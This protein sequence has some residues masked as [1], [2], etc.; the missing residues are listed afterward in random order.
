MK[1]RTFVLLT[2]A[3]VIIMILAII[4]IIIINTKED[5]I[6]E[7]H[8]EQHIDF[9]ELDN[10][11]D[12]NEYYTVK[13]IIS[14]YYTNVGYLD[15]N[16]EDLNLADE[17]IDEASIV[18]EYNQYATEIL[19][20]MIDKE[21]I[22]SLNLND[23][24]IIDTLKEYKN[25]A[26][27]I[28]E[29]YKSE[30][31]INTSIYFVKLK[32]NYQKDCSII[33]KKD[34]YNKTFSIYPE[35]YVQ[36]NN[37]TENDIET[38]FNIEEIEYIDKNDNNTYT[39][40]ELDDKV[41]AFNYLMEYGQAVQYNAK[42]AYNLLDEEYKQKRFPTYNDYATYIEQS[43]K[44]YNYLQ[45]QGFL[46]DASE[47]GNIYT[48]LDQYNTVFIIKELENMKFSV[49]L[50]DYTI[51]DEAYIK[52]YNA[53]ESMN[54]AIV[55]LG[56]FVEMI[57]MRDYKSAY[58]VLDQEFKAKY[59]NTLQ[60]FENYMKE[61]SF[62]YNNVSYEEYGNQI[63]GIHT[64]KVILSDATGENENTI[65]FNAVIKLLEDTNFVM[66]FEV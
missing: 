52:T 3:I 17:D 5:I 60:D 30:K 41:I 18:E 23:N 29:M 16:I 38:R 54:K 13:S 24:N 53:S 42:E 46:V 6:I 20:D 62:S 63:K 25:K 4:G 22:E 56:K 12:I 49:Q 47:N 43:Q 27:K 50:D 36:I 14:S 28:E 10:V 61:H 51:Q 64:L 39:Q 15:A 1:T 55:C 40:Q 35:P 11:T 19:M 59:F 65:Q 32:L 33:I 66:S 26:F 58:D 48:C 31:S 37:L 34:S 7:S 44:E 57:N 8:E 2:V 21:A 45:L 9:S